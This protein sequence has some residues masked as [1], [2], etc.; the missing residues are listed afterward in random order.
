[1]DLT[2]AI[3]RPLCGTRFKLQ[4]V[5]DC[6]NWRSSEED[7]NDSEAV[8]GRLAPPQMKPGRL[9]PVAVVQYTDRYINMMKRSIGD[10]A[11]SKNTWL[12][13]SVH[14]I[15]VSKLLSSLYCF[16]FH[17]GY[18]CLFSFKSRIDVPKSV[19]WMVGLP[20]GRVCSQLVC[21]SSRCI[22]LT[23]R[24]SLCKTRGCLT[25]FCIYK[26][27]LFTG[28]HQQRAALPPMD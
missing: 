24:T 18:K 13:F 3:T 12:R 15:W 9:S 28:L 26:C 14:F 6:F 19:T 5:F 23:G 7:E 17:L 27:N 1:M 8:Y 21:C 20:F 4:F 16:W 22:L 2:I 10:I 11:K 25:Q